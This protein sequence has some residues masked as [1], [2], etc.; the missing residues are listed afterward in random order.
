MV[1]FKYKSSLE[2]SSLTLP[3][4]VLDAQMFEKYT[5]NDHNIVQLVSSGSSVYIH[6]AL[7]KNV[8]PFLAD[9]L[10][11]S[12]VGDECVLLLPASSPLT[13]R[14]LVKLLCT[15]C[16]SG[17]SGRNLQNLL[18]L[19]KIL[20]LNISSEK[21]DFVDDDIASGDNLIEQDSDNN[22]LK[23]K[24]NIFNKHES[25]TLSLPKSRSNRILSTDI[26]Q[27]M[28]GFHG[29]VQEEYNSHP[30][31]KYMGPYD[32]NK[33]LSL[34]IQLPE[35]N[36]DFKNY[37]EFHH[38][39]N[40]CFDLSLSCY[41]K[42]SD[43]AK[44]DSYQFTVEKISIDESDSDIDDSDHKHEK[45]MYT[46]Q[47]RKCKI[48]CPCPQCHLN[49]EQCSEHKIKHPS[50]FD[51]TNHMIS[52]KSSEEYCV[53]EDFF[54][55]SYISKFSGIP[56]ECNKCKQD[57]LYHHSYHLEYHESCRFCKQSWHKHKAKTEQEFHDLVR[58]ETAYFKRVCPLCDKQF[59]QPYHM[60]RHMENEHKKAKFSCDYC[61]KFFQ[62]KQA[63]L[64]HERLKHSTSKD[65]DLLE[66]KKCEKSFTSEV[67]LKSHM[68]YA[69]S[70]ERHQS[71][72]HCNTKFKQEKN[73]RA[74]LL[75]IHGIDQ[76]RERYCEE[77]DHNI[78]KCEDC[79]STFSY[80][81]SLTLHRKTKHEDKPVYDC[82]ICCARFSY[83]HKLV[84]HIKVKHK[85]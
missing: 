80:K 33:E 34:K 52:I 66:C 18:E 27:K 53:D 47:F 73:L 75:N 56:R 8:S 55:K 78:F 7:L 51:E 10:C 16:V 82:K 67:N 12:P 40:K 3:E 84:E 6:K 54:K 26:P 43:L 85:V 35:S 9:I 21:V 2:I 58:D 31:G 45:K 13:L 61:R 25:L 50:L 83:K 14:S 71:C 17:L 24:T 65:T 72:P 76:M 4:A 41:E 1:P 32:Q 46:C 60:K 69:H 68:K 5:R 44:I 49:M 63:K 79:D 11:S 15:G 59:I 81:R 70:E 64:Y 74:H 48:P 42:Y 19:A 77:K 29:R 30:V 22:M 23:I 57:L 62:S 28:T 37:T 39:G 38:D 36:L 20:N